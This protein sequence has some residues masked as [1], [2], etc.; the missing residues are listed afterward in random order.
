MS[1]NN[2]ETDNGTLDQI[3]TPL[4][5]G[6]E[7]NSHD[8][9]FIEGSRDNRI[10]QQTRANMDTTGFIPNEQKKKELE[11]LEKDANELVKHVDKNSRSSIKDLTINQIIQN[12]S[13]SIIGL[14]ND[15]FLKPSET[16]WTTYLSEIFQKNDRYVYV[17]ILMVVFALLVSYF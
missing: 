4:I 17:G 8:N 5:I 16:K 7:K 9:P 13:D 6:L 14:L 10:L 12:L 2:Q 15:L 11:E 1:Y 3:K